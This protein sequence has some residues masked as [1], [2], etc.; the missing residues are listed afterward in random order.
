MNTRDALLRGAKYLEAQAAVVA[1]LVMEPTRVDGPLAWPV[2]ATEE[3]QRHDD[4]LAIAQHLLLLARK[5]A[6]QIKVDA[7][8]P[9]PSK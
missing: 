5:P 9:F 7:G 4:M 2:D 1:A 6:E 3:K 8:W